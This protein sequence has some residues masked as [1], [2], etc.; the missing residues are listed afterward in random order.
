MY[1]FDAETTNKKFLLNCFSLKYLTNKYYEKKTYIGKQVFKLLVNLFDKKISEV[2][3]NVE[4]TNRD[5]Q[6]R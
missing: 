3:Q 1:P 5:N 6:K 2:C 4:E